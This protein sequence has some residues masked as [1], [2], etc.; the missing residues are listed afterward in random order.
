M[1]ALVSALDPLLDAPPVDTAALGRGSLLQRLRAL[2]TL[3]PLLRTG[4]SGMSGD[5]DGHECLPAPGVGN[6]ELPL[7]G[8]SLSKSPSWASRLWQAC[9]AA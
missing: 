8:H 9:P 4:T 1:G 2:R 6:V 3:R 7:P 5:P